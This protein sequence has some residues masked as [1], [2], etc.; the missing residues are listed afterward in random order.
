MEARVLLDNALRIESLRVAQLGIHID[1]D[2]QV[3][4]IARRAQQPLG[5]L[6]RE[7]DKCVVAGFG[8]DH[9]IAHGTL[10]GAALQLFADFAYTGS[11]LHKSRV[12]HPFVVLDF[13]EDLIDIDNTV[14]ALVVEAGGL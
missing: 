10:D 6:T 11:G 4:P 9:D 7:Q 8:D 14:E 1:I 12:R 13:L 3:G 5:Q 2:A